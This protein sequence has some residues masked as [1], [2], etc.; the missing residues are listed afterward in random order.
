MN[1][2]L[3]GGL[4]AALAL[5]AAPAF[6]DTAARADARIVLKAGVGL[7]GKGYFAPVSYDEELE[8]KVL[9][10]V[11]AIRA[12]YGLPELRADSRGTRA[13]RLAAAEAS[14]EGGFGDISAGVGARLREQ[15][16]GAGFEVGELHRQV[17]ESRLDKEAQTIVQAW[18]RDPRQSRLLLDKDLTYAGVGAVSRGGKLFVALDAFG[19]KPVIQPKPHC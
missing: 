14:R 7:P 15:G 6:A 16:V 5:T 4:F 9:A 18:L 13:A 10:R 17:K 8:A 12:R 1:R 19:P 3:F 11:N 2:S